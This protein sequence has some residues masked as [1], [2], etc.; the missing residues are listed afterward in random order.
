[1]QFVGGL[2]KKQKVALCPSQGAGSQTS[3][4]A[5]MGVGHDVNFSATR[6]VYQADVFPRSCV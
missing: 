6:D 4:G 2:N 5:V 3:R 1:M